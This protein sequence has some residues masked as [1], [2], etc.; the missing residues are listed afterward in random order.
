MEQDQRIAD[1][2]FQQRAKESRLVESIS[3]IL[4]NEFKEFFV[5]GMKEKVSQIKPNLET[6]QANVDNSKLSDADFRAF[7]KNV[8]PE[9]L[10]RTCKV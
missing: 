5:L 4:Y 10:K 1:L 7:I 8:I 9:L 6:I 3:P 2:H